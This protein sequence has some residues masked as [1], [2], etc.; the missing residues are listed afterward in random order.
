MNDIF[1]SF[2]ISTKTQ[3]EVDT[4]VTGSRL[5]GKSHYRTGTAQMGGSGIGLSGNGQSL[6]HLTPDTLTIAL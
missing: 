3:L 6:E 2:D 4:E 1:D 5:L